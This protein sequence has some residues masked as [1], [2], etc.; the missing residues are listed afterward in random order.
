MEISV[1]EVQKQVYDENIAN[2]VPGI[3]ERYPHTDDNGRAD[4]KHDE[5]KH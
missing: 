4:E 5:V 3:G 1:V 2:V